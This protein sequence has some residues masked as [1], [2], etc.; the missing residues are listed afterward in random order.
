MIEDAHGSDAPSEDS[1][2][3]KQ[4]RLAVLIPVFNDQHGLERS[5]A[6]LAQ[7]GAQ[8]D[9]FVVDDGSEPP[10]RPPGDLPFSINLIRQKRNQGITAALNAGLSTIVA[11][12]YDYIA[13]LD[14]GDLSLPGRLAAQ[15]HFLDCHPDHAAVGTA[16]AVC[17][18]QRRSV[19]RL[20]SASGSRGVA[21]ILSLPRR[22]RSSVG[23]DPGSGV[24]RLRFL[25]G[26]ISRWR[27]LR[28]VH[29]PFEGIQAGKSERQLR[30]KRG[31]SWIDYIK[32][33]VD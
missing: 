30:R 21:P 26:K 10:I 16:S 19:V 5:L 28:F 6:S 9:V 4:P 14:A 15:M 8:F 33:I 25:S 2:G 23:H 27:G 29:A 11:A 13:R 7:D 20:R 12:G 22:N 24:A 32:A 18:Y 3:G 31:S 1:V 17:R